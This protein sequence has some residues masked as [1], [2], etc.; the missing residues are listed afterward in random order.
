M[1]EVPAVKLPTAS[2]WGYRATAISP[3]SLV[4]RVAAETERAVD[5]YA[6]LPEGPDPCNESPGYERVSAVIPLTAKLFGQLM[7]GRTGYRA[8]YSVSVAAGERFNRV[9]VEQLAPIIVRA[10][11][12]YRDKFSTELCAASL[13]GPH[14]KFWFTRQLTDPSAQAQLLQQPEVIRVPRW[15]E[16]WRTRP[17]PRKGLLAPTPE[18][19][20]VLLN[21]SFVN[22]AGRYYEQKPGRSKELFKC[23]WT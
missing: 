9:L 20:A 6:V 22:V 13:L 4:E 8:H 21:G 14:S 2:V 10:T 1:S 12:R 16:Y 18:P 17:Q 19:C 3:A 7:N 23:G 5:E 15:S 11:Q